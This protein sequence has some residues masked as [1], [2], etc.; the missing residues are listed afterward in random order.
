MLQFN[1]CDFTKGNNYFQLISRTL[2]LYEVSTARPEFKGLATVLAGTCK[3][4]TIFQILCFEAMFYSVGSTAPRMTEVY[5]YLTII[6]DIKSYCNYIIYTTFT[7]NS[8]PFDKKHSKY[9]QCETIDS[10]RSNY[11]IR[12]D[13]SVPIY[14]I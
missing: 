6:K 12:Y 5:E 10:F 7:G 13:S 14:N 2:E 11:S 9:C 8:S 1:F 3:E 4:K